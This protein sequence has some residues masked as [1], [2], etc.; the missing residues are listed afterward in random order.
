MD[1][2]VKQPKMKRPFTTTPDDGGVLDLLGKTKPEVSAKV[3]VGTVKIT[4]VEIVPATPA[5]P[6]RVGS[7]ALAAEQAAGR[8]TLLDKFG[9]NSLA[10]EQSAGAKTLGTGE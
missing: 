8:K 4:N 5:E 10:Q 3:E 6:V 1:D 2:D 7:A 9:G